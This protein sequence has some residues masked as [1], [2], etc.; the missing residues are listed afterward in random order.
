[1]DDNRL[2]SRAME[3]HYPAID[4]LIRDSLDEAQVTGV[5]REMVDYQM[6]AG[7]KRLRAL[8]PPTL[9]EAL[10]GAPELAYPFGAACELVHNATLAHDDFQDGDDTRRGI[11]TLWVRW[12]AA[13]AINA[14][15]VMLMLP[16]HLLGKLRC[17]DGTRL[18]LSALYAR[19][20]VDVVSGQ[21]YEMALREGY[22][23]TPKDY[24]RMVEGKTSALFGLPMVGASLLAGAGPETLDAMAFVGRQVGVLFQLVDDFIDLYGDKGRGQS[25]CDIREGKPSLL[26]AHALSHADEAEAACLRDILRR[27]RPDTSL[28]DVDWA[29]RLFHRLGSVGYLQEQARQRS[30][31]VRA[32]VSQLPESV[33]LPVS[34]VVEGLLSKLEEPLRK[35]G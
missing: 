30:I 24:E 8:L 16:L 6:G 11:P 17:D 13:Q 29:S 2:F 1:M 33:R 3:R 21:S 31:A 12:G 4:H 28:D 20:L 15:D 7:G 14:G 35:V 32:S 27:P 9:L 26:V 10:G 34:R 25:G 22:C 19:S 18:A 5:L 23:F